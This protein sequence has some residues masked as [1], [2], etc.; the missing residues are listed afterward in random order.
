MQTRC[1]S[2]ESS[3]ETSRKS[4][5]QPNRLGRAPNPRLQRPALLRPHGSQSSSPSV[6][7][8]SRRVQRVSMPLGVRTASASAAHAGLLRQPQHLLTTKPA[9]AAGR[10]PGAATICKTRAP[11]WISPTTFATKP[12]V[13]RDKAQ[14]TPIVAAHPARRG[15]VDPQSLHAQNGASQP[16]R[17]PPSAAPV[18]RHICQPPNT[19]FCFPK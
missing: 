10:P 18:S 4:A 9:P 13:Y 2:A 3:W 5:P 15:V 12:S 6:R 1:F 8:C 14:K 19:R 11:R 16:R 7:Q 17:P